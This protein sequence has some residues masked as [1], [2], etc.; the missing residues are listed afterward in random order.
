MNIVIWAQTQ[1]MDV[2][3]TVDRMLPGLGEAIEEDL[4]KL[5]TS[6]PT[7]RE[8]KS[9]RHTTR[10]R[11]KVAV[12]VGLVAVGMAGILDPTKAWQAR[13]IQLAF[14]LAGAYVGSL[15]GPAG[16]TIGFGVGSVIGGGVAFAYLYALPVYTVATG[17]YLV[18]TG[19]YE[20]VT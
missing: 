15:L 1:T 8:V 13:K 4:H 14:A 16:G 6:Q 17:A 9:K 12:G 20:M 2:L 5:A 7:Y 18:I 10:G 11:A 3:R 19:L